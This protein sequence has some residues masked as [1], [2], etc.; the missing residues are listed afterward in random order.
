[1]NRPCSIRR[2]LA[3]A[4]LS[5]LTGLTAW[6]AVRGADSP[7]GREIKS[8][9][10]RQAH[11][12][13]SLEVSYKLDVTSPL[14]PQELVALAQFR[15]QMFLPRDEWHEAFKGGK[16]YQRQIIL[17]KVDFLRPTDEHGLFPPAPVDP[18]ATAFVQK[19]QK[20]VIEEY[21]RA[22]ARL[23]AW[24][25]RDE[26]AIVVSKDP[27]PDTTRAFNGRTLWMRH[28]ESNKVD[29]YQVWPA[30]SEANWFQATSYMRATGLHVP[31]PTGTGMASKT[32][33]MFRV[34]EWVNDHGYELE[35]KTEVIDGSTCVVLKGSLNSLLQAIITSGDLTDRVWLDRDHGLAVRQREFAKDGRIGMRWTNTDL[36]EVE[37]GLWLPFHCRQEQ[38]AEDAPPE[39]KDKPVMVEEIRVLSVEVNKVSDELFD[40]T[41]KKSDHVED[42]RGQ[43]TGK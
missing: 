36:R 20:K 33:A 32:Q 7:E 28:P 9:L 5:L 11:R 24:K 1:M 17:G 8:R 41:P 37:P 6:L 13:E 22:V 18:K 26:R 34:A 30:R 39:W 27:V 2:S 15:N 35:E 23:K 43:L 42:L 40:M 14:K 3:F 10:R 31:D 38:Y 12:I 4:G 25:A 29:A 16:R 19:E 21:E